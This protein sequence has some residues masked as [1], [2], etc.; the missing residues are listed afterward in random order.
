[1]FRNIL[2]AL[3]QSRTS[4]RALAE[5]T[6]LA[7]ALNARLT[8]ISV[9]PPVPPY[10]YR[11]G[12]DVGALEK[13]VEEETEKT[14]REAVEGLP[15]DLPVTTVI[16]HGH[17]GEEIVKQIEA[18]DHDLVAMG[19]RGLGRVSANLFGTVGGYVH[20]HARTST[21]MLVIHPEQ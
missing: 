1:M 16:K 4:Q 21:A 13:E 5:A 12:V 8:I 6:D 18:G 7:E 19:S 9:A 15:K 2:V 10:A 14:M 11:A 17:P 20:F 3:D